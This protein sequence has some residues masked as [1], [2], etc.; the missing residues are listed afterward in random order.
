[1]SRLDFLSAHYKNKKAGEF[2][3]TDNLL[4]PVKIQIT[5]FVN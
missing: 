4:K 5:I 3:S 1:M 2:D